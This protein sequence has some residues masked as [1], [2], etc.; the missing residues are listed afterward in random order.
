[1]RCQI[2][3]FAFA[4]DYRVFLRFVSILCTLVVAASVQHSNDTEYVGGFSNEYQ[5]LPYYTT[6][7]PNDAA[8]LKSI[9][10]ND[11]ETAIEFQNRLCHERC[12][13]TRHASPAYSEECWRC[14]PCTCSS[15]CDKEGTC[16]PQV[17]LDWVP[18]AID[19]AECRHDFVEKN[20]G[21][22]QVVKCH[23]AF[24]PGNERDLCESKTLPRRRDTVLPVTSNDSFVTYVNAHCAACNYDD[25]EAVE[26]GVRCL[27]NQYLYDAMND[28]RYDDSAIH[29]PD[30]CGFVRNPSIPFVDYHCCPDLSSF[31]GH[32]VSS[33]NVD[34]HWA[35]TDEDVRKACEESQRSIGTTLLVKNGGLYA[36]AFCARCNEDEWVSIHCKYGTHWPDIVLLFLRS[37]IELIS[38]PLPD[39]VHTIWTPVRSDCVE[40]YWPHPEGECR[41]LQCAAGKTLQGGRCTTAVSRVTGLGYRLHILLRPLVLSYTRMVNTRTTRLGPAQSSRTCHY[42]KALLLAM[43][44][45]VG[46]SIVDRSVNI[47]T[48]AAAIE[49]CFA[50]TYKKRLKRLM[51]HENTTSKDNG[52]RTVFELNVEAMASN[53]AWFLTAK[54]EAHLLANPI[55]E[56]DFVEDD[57]AFSVFDQEWIVQLGKWTLR[58]KA[59]DVS[60]ELLH[61]GKEQSDLAVYGV[62]DVDK[63]MLPYKTNTSPL[64]GL[65]H[66][67]LPFTCELL[68][69]H[70]RFERDEFTLVTCDEC[71]T[72]VKFLYFLDS[73][74]NP[75]TFL[76]KFY[77][78]RAWLT[79][80]GQLAMC[81]DTFSDVFPQN[82]TVVKPVLRQASMVRQIMSAVC[83]SVSVACLAVTFTTYA[84]FPQLRALPGLNNMGL[85]FSLATAQLSLLLPW[86]LTGV[87]EVCRAVGVFTHW[88]WLTAFGW[89]GV[90]C[91][92]M[93][94][95]FTS[96]THHSLSERE[97]KKAF[98]HHVLATCLFSSVIVV[99]TVVVSS[100]MSAGASMGYGG[101]ICFLDTEL[102]R[103]ILLAVLL[104][105]G[106]VV[107]TNLTCFTITVVAI[108]RVRRL[109]TRAPR[110]RRDVLVYAKLV[111]VTGGAWVLGFLAEL[112][113]Q[114]WMRGVAELCIAAQGLLLFLAY[115]C[116]KRV[117]RLYRARFGRSPP[118]DATTSSTPA[119][120]LTTTNTVQSS[121]A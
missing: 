82:V 90:C 57:I 16:C 96:K 75:L 38:E 67:F 102:H 94:R 26:W 33:C 103:H 84:L 98:L 11:R 89:M 74:Y 23:R 116:N 1:M 21:V 113:D 111:T 105:L 48:A 92:H 58:L 27:H 61:G 120:A 8:T 69:P 101:P 68:C 46:N 15:Y 19:K 29:M 36:N 112:T 55:K 13:G 31:T 117:W 85:S 42:E 109:Q 43:E 20:V 44:F 106:L 100:A 81:M 64:I 86:H 99:I 39:I 56:R 6:K 40:G 25:E 17:G 9:W 78:H 10:D 121:E 87:A 3:E 45:N 70:L 108:V 80:D 28:A 47:T 118:P 12:N 37:S 66:L 7:Y 49:T 88:A 50:K 79:E 63:T 30:L 104:P 65:E 114:E 76:A 35:E 24:P 52:D 18:P 5:T 110:E 119:T 97:A 32:A 53:E 22:L 54:V 95:V 62:S 34:G 2:V 83:G 60:T 71:D 77:P 51:K 93:V 72:Q 107:L 73:D 41:E 115:A 59:F 14:F 4:M 91:V